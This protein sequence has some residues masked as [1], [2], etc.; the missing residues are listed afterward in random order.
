MQEGLILFSQWERNQP[1][2]QIHSLVHKLSRGAVTQNLFSGRDKRRD[3]PTAPRDGC[4][5]RQR[6]KELPRVTHE[7]LRRKNQGHSPLENQGRRRA[8]R[9]IPTFTALFRLQSYQELQE[10]TYPLLQHYLKQTPYFINP[11]IS[12]LQESFPLGALGKTFGL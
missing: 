11:F 7:S 12:G 1:L 5:G 3:V 4:S 2:A 6:Q 10:I 9:A 8:N